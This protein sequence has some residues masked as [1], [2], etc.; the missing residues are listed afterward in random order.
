MRI[1]RCPYISLSNPYVDTILLGL[2]SALNDPVHHPSAHRP[3]CWP[4]FLFSEHLT[5]DES[6]LPTLISHPLI[7]PP[8]IRPFS[9]TVYLRRSSTTNDF[10]SGIFTCLGQSLR[11]ARGRCEGQICWVKLIKRMSSGRARRNLTR[12]LALYRFAVSSESGCP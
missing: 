9:V 4:T 11:G 1:T 10:S 5:G 3:V 12:Q 2:H 6:N 8:G 7:E